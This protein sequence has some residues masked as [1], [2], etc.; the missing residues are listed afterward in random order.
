[1]CNLYQTHAGFTDDLICSKK[2]VAQPAENFDAAAAIALLEI[3]KNT[4]I[5]MQKFLVI[6]SC[7]EMFEWRFV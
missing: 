2:S 7:L 1:M 3:G 4:C 6:V 5:A